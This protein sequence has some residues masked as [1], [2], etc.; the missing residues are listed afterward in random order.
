MGFQR[1]GKTHLRPEEAM[2][3]LEKNSLIVSSDACGE[4]S[5]LSLLEMQKL[6]EGAGVSTEAYL[7]YKELMNAS[8]IVTRHPALWI[9]P[10]AYE[11]HKLEG[12][13]SLPAVKASSP[14]PSKRRRLDDDNRCADV[15][16]AAVVE[17]QAGQR[18][19]WPAV[20]SSWEDSHC[21]S[22]A[23]PGTGASVGRDRGLVLPH[24]PNLRPLRACPAAEASSATPQ[25]PSMAYDVYKGNSRFSK[26][27]P[28][29]LAMQVHMSQS[30][31]PSRDAM[32]AAEAACCENE[33]VFFATAADKHVSMYS[34][35]S[36][37]VPDL[38]QHAAQ[39]HEPG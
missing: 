33:A 34:F 37:C 13:A 18:H 17:V 38:L 15:Q 30:R 2:Y 7:V 9:V 5:T 28:S 23:A 16:L 20:D 35:T 3:L 29:G 8:L 1:D 19:W 21:A 32:C 10:K 22:K 27:R 31:P 4:A 39:S 14:P 26:K 6:M 12:H 36:I 24:R 25:Q 11:G